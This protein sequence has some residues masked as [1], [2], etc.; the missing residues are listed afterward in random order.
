VWYSYF[1]IVR[2]LIYF[3]QIRHEFFA[4]DHLFIQCGLFA[5]FF[6]GLFWSITLFKKCANKLSITT[7]KLD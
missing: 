2:F 5:L 7:N 1:R 3:V 6:L 4:F